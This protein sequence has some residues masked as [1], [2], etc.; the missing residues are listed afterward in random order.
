MA[1][2]KE[3]R[4]ERKAR[5]DEIRKKRDRGERDDGPPPYRGEPERGGS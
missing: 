4:E 1:D 3:E 5:E 2:G